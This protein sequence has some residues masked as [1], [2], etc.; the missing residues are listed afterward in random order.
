VSPRFPALL[1]VAALVALAGCGG[2]LPGGDA[3]PNPDA[4]LER[5]DPLYDTPLEGS[6]LLAGHEAALRDAETVTVVRNTTITGT[7]PG[8]G[9]ESM[10]TARVS[11]AD[12]R[13]YVV[14]RPAPVTQTYRYANDTA[15]S[16]SASGNSC[17]RVENDTEGRTAV[18]WTRA[19][20]ERFLPLASFTHRGVAERDGERVHVYRAT[21]TAAVNVS[22][23]TPG[24]STGVEL[25]AVNVTLRV[26]ESGAVSHLQFAYTV[27]D[28]DKRREVTASV[29]FSDLGETNVSPP[30][31]VAD[32]RERLADDE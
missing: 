22:T 11:L 10:T 27:E 32:L 8:A 26:R 12:G 15:F 30:A 24:D 18:E 4:D 13:V 23:V 17:S 29:T 1:A 9:F 28:G 20:L 21:D 3:A 7:G 5:A 31:W 14:E 16:R 2:A 19:P 6:D 25:T